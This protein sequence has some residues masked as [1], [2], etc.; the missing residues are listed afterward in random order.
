MKREELFNKNRN[1]AEEM[2]K[3]ELIAHLKALTDN[4]NNLIATI[5]E[6]KQRADDPFLQ[7][8]TP[9][10]IK[11]LPTFNGSKK[12]TQAWIEDAENTLGLFEQYRDQAVYSQ[13][14]RAVKNKIIGE[15]KEILIAAGNPNDWEQIK[16]IIINSYG[17]RRDLTSHI[18]S[19][20]YI[21][22]DRKTIPDYYN[23]IKTIDTA[24]KSTAAT[25]ED[26]KTSTKAINSLVSLITLTRFID[27]LNDDLPMHVRSYR[28]KSLEEAYAITTQ[29]AN[30]AYRQKLNKKPAT[31]GADRNF[32]KNPKQTGSYFN[33][34][35]NA[36]NTKPNNTYFNS[37]NNQQNTKPQGSGKFRTNRSLTSDD[38]V[39]MRTARSRTDINNHNQNKK[40]QEHDSDDEPEYDPSDEKAENSKLDSDDDDYLLTDEINFLLTRV[41][42]REK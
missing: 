22:Q 26:Y 23:K 33:N 34:N 13:L 17:D 38:D 42:D 3:A 30:A 41:K 36:S 32:N 31:Q 24:I 28:P 2:T 10:P 9:D 8:K 15:A 7:F 25:M 18:Q 40:Q 14:V 19:L 11:N 4:Q 29:Y 35:G 6:L 21:S 20:F 16:E 37:N 5:S 27:G 39:S 12:E 1:M